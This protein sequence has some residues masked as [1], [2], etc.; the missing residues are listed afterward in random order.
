[1]AIVRAVADCEPVEVAFLGYGPEETE[2]KQTAIALNAGARIHFLDPVPPDRIR[3]V[4]AGADAGITLLED[5]CLNH[6]FALPN[7]LFDYLAAGLPVLGSRLPEIDRIVKGRDV[8]LTVDPEDHDELVSGLR[9]LA[10]DTDARAQ[11]ATHALAAA[12][13]FDW[14]SASERY[15][16]EI[17]RLLRPGIPS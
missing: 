4:I 13:T 14:G 9:R 3:P 2:L 16:S 10:T 17:G 11:W 15:T 1:M 7:K 8:G 6:R 5:T 12:E